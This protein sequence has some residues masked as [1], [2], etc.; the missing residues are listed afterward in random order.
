M[1][2][3]SEHCEPDS[4][5]KRSCHDRKALGLNLGESGKEGLAQTLCFAFHGY[6]QVYDRAGNRR[7]GKEKKF[8][9]LLS[10]KIST[11]KIFFSYFTRGIN[12]FN[13]N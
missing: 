7:E 13:S 2:L 6:D 9:V 12:S 4:V 1:K 8:F 3:Y 5:K 10:Q 11:K